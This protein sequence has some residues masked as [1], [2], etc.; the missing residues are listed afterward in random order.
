MKL[1][2]TSNYG[3]KINHGIHFG[4]YQWD[5]ANPKMKTTDL[6]GGCTRL[7][8]QET[9]RIGKG[10][11]LLQLGNV[12]GTRKGPYV[13][14]RHKWKDIK[15]LVKQG[16]TVWY[17]D[18]PSL[19]HLLYQGAHNPKGFKNWMRLCKNN[20]ITDPST[21]PRPGQTGAS[22][23]N[24]QLQDI[25]DGKLCTWHDIVGT[26]G[27]PQDNNHM[28]AMICPSSAEIFRHYYKTTLEQWVD[29]KRKI[30]EQHGYTV[31][32]RLKPGRAQRNSGGELW[33]E[34][35]QKRIGVA[36]SMHSVGSVE[37]LVAGVPVIV[38]GTNPTGQLNTPWAQ[39]S[40]T[41]VL[42][43]PTVA[44]VDVLVE[45]LLHDVYHKTEA[46]QGQLL[47]N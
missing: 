35:Q 37:S 2:A 33:R 16:A 38:D 22:R 30:L 44:Q 46:Y 40:R 6:G 43:K 15:Q 29:S 36:V 18:N 26:R 32:V 42:H 5:V 3:T 41:G 23:I 13:N 20:I 10:D 9:G 8:A 45:R 7:I 25:T 27:N 14:D 47:L 34:L 39:F 17:W 24:Q 19:P 12:W 4:L 28:R 1:Y 31:E 11:T 21:Q